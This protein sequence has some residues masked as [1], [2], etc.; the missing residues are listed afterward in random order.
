MGL[1]SKSER[2]ESSSPLTLES[3]LP[4]CFETNTSFRHLRVTSFDW[5]VGW[6][7]GYDVCPLSVYVLPVGRALTI[8]CIRT[9]L[10]TWY[11]TFS[12]LGSSPVP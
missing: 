5:C 8:L 4:A 12:C 11:F 6:R 2:S 3:D 9:Y 10:N 1:L 7:W